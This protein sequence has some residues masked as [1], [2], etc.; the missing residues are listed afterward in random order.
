M[1][2]TLS[3][4]YVATDSIG[5]VAKAH[6]AIPLSVV[7][8]SSDRA[9]RVQRYSLILFGFDE[10]TVERRNE[11]EIGK[12]AALLPNIAVA[13]ML[14]QGYTDETGEAAHNDELSETRAKE[15]RKRL[16]LIMKQRDI[17]PL[18]RVETEGRGSRDA[19]YDNSLPEGRFF[20]RT[21][22]ITIERQAP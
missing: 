3:I 2:D 11:R 19:L 8:V 10:S 20:S 18:R 5:N 13:R 17:P 9:E 21:V 7:K 6:T 14:I 1:S 22:N 12:V 4:D 16:E 15:V